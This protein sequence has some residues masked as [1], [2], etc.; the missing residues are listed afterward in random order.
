[1]Y[2]DRPSSS[3]RSHRIDAKQASTFELQ[4]AVFEWTLR[5]N[6]GLPAR[7]WHSSVIF[8]GLVYVIAGLSG[9]SVYYNDVWTY[10]TSTSMSL[11]VSYLFLTLTAY[12]AT[13]CRRMVSSP[14]K[15][16]P[17]HRET[18]SHLFTPHSHE[19]DLHLWRL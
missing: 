6:T 18:W 4:G 2:V 8:S 19:H 11:P 16:C 12:F 3:G 14:D 9:G 13:V 10:T 5:S 7:Y 17:H 15:W 1:M